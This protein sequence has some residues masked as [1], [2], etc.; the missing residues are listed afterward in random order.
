MMAKVILAVLLTLLAS[1]F[2]GSAVYA[3]GP[4]PAAGD[5]EAMS[6]V[7]GPDRLWWG[8]FSGG[9]KSKNSLFRDGGVDYHTAELC[10]ASR[11]SCEAWLYR[12]K[13][14]WQY[15]PRWNECLRGYRG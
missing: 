5:C 4:R 1:S 6:E 3:Q 10:F 12:L 14:D 2:S 7:Y 8:R 15:M 13:S 11:Q 9:R